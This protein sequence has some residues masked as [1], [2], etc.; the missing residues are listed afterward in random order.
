[1]LCWLVVLRASV[2]YAEVNMRHLMRKPAFRDLCDKERFKP[3]CSAT[4]GSKSLGI[5]DIMVV[6]YYTI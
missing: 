1:M 5:H 2:K 4:E 3:I 6:G